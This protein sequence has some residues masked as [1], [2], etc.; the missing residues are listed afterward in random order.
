MSPAFGNLLAQ[1]GYKVEV[2]QGFAPPLTDLINSGFMMR[3]LERV[4]SFL[5]RHMPNLFAYN[6]LVI[7]T[8]MDGIE[9]ILK[10][11]TATMKAAGS[12]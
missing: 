11:T 10:Q 2:V 8:R 1:Y 4:H 3:L 7:A 12:Q 5:S 6:F 9:D